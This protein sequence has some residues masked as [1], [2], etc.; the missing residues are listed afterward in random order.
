MEARGVPWKER[1]TKHARI[2]FNREAP[3]EAEASNARRDD[4]GMDMVLVGELGMI[5]E[6]DIVTVQVLRDG[7]PLPDL[8]VEL[9]HVSQGAA[10]SAGAWHRTDDQGLL[11]L[12]VPQAGTWL[13][14]GIDIRKS[15]SV[16][17]SWD[18]RFVTLAFEVAVARRRDASGDVASRVRGA[19]R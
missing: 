2:V 5:R 3:S 9:R 11:R 4:M 14:R 8:A 1:Y 12:L 16:P 7:Q 17:D 19:A 10:V 6:A 18:T 15:D 13:L